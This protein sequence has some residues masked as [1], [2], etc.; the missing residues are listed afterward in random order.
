MMFMTLN[1]NNQK[2]TRRSK[3]KEREI[4]ILR[5]AYKYFI[6]LMRFTLQSYKFC[7]KWGKVRESQRK[8]T[9][10]HSLSY[11]Y[12]LISLYFT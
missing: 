5:F 12:I 11:T 3:V 6:L 2:V 10:K 8:T 7:E 4:L 9:G 1:I